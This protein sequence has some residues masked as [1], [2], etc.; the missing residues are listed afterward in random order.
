MQMP[1][2]VPWQVAIRRVATFDVRTVAELPDSK[3]R[4][5]Y[6][7]IVKLSYL[8]P[9]THKSRKLLDAALD[10]FTSELGRRSEV[11]A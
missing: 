10:N 3:L 4:A 2:K 9:A 5:G 6:E 1:N 7:A 11:S 8:V